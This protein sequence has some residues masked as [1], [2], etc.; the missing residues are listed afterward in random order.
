MNYPPIPIPQNSGIDYQHITNVD[1]VHHQGIYQTDSNSLYLSIGCCFKYFPI[2][3]LVCGVC[4]MPLYFVAKGDARY[5]VIVIGAIF[6]LISIFMMFR[7]YYS[8]YFYMGINDLTV[9]KKALCSR[10]T[11]VYGPGDLISIE[12]SHDV[13]YKRKKEKK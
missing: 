5:S 7:G 10:D 11:T 9:T 12:L 8:V 4:I 6:V 3:F 1:Q 13:R 2:I